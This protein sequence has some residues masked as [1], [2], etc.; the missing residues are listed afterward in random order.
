MQQDE[1]ATPRRRNGMYGPCAGE[2]GKELVPGDRIRFW[3]G[4]FYCLE[5]GDRAEECGDMV[6]AVVVVREREAAES[7]VS[8]VCLPGK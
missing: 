5:C 1:P 7:A 3:R 8:V 6:Q 4:R 2:C